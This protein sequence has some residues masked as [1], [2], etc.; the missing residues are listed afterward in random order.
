MPSNVL[1]L[2]RQGGVRLN[3]PGANTVAHKTS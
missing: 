2:V 1:D 3:V